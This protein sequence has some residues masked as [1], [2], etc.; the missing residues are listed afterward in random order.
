MLYTSQSV[1]RLDGIPAVSSRPSAGGHEQERSGS[2]SRTTTRASNEAERRAFSGFLARR[3]TKKS[4]AA[5]SKELNY[6][7]AEPKRKLKML[8]ARA[9]EW[10]N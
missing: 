3:A 10:S 7:K 4:A 6:N 2:P 9:K 5:R 1:D 8:E